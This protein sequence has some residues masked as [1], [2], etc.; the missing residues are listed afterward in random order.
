[1]GADSR[2]KCSPAS[3]V[4]SFITMFPWAP[5]R[6]LRRAARSRDEGFRRWQPATQGAKLWNGSPASSV[7]RRFAS[8]RSRAATARGASAFGG[9]G[10]ATQGTWFI[11][12][13]WRLPSK[14]LPPPEAIAFSEVAASA[15]QRT[16]PTTA[17]RHP[18]FEGASPR[19]GGALRLGRESPYRHGSR[20]LPITEL[21]DAK[22]DSRRLPRSSEARELELEIRRAGRVL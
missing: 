19:K 8:G 16:R 7:R 1:M 13:D 11:V 5:C 20:R 17:A 6:H 21:R 22:L 18:P 2:R 10:Q 12:A 14:G 4:L 9:G 3:L 15:T